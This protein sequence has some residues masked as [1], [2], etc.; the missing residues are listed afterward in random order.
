MSKFGRNH[1]RSTDV[2]NYRKMD[3]SDIWP[4]VQIQTGPSYRRNTV[5]CP[6]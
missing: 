6:S 2:T 4:T 3:L 5:L 1:I